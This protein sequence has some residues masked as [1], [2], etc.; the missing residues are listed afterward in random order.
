MLN[1]LR[2]KFVRNS[3]IPAGLQ[4]WVVPG[5]VHIYKTQAVPF[6]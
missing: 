3:A 5:M 2:G 4:T 1:I 6:R